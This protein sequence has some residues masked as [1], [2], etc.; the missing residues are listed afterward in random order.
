MADLS[1]RPLVDDDHEA[2]LATLA[3]WSGGQDMHALL[4]RLFF[5]H[6]SDTSLVV[7]D[8]ERSLIGFVIAFVSQTRADTGYIHL[9][10]VRPDARHHGVARGLYLRIFDLLRQRGC[11]RV[12]AV[13]IPENTG[14]LAFHDRMGFT[15]M[16]H[17]GRPHEAPVFSHHA[18][19]GQHR[20]K[21]ERT[22]WDARDGLS[23]SAGRAQ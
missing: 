14:S 8:A 13:T 1:W 5:S 19:P 2:V 18:G 6:F 22:L 16:G 9:V 10:W 11:Q 17:G 12:E 4:P 23:R 20:V 7:E 15:A 3:A 21:L